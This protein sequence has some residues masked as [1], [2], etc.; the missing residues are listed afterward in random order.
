MNTGD[1]EYEMKVI[2]ETERIDRIIRYSDD[3]EIMEIFF[4]PLE[5]M[6]SIKKGRKNDNANH[7][8]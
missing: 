3:P 2:K 7:A 6:S 1:Q 5:N 8:A 4:S